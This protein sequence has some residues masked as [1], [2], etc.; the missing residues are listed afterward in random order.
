[1]KA[2]E[3]IDRALPGP[4]VTGAEVTG[5][6]SRFQL[7]ASR[8]PYYWRLLK[9]LPYGA[10]RRI[11]RHKCHGYRVMEPFFNGSYGL[12]MGGPSP[13]FSRNKLIPVY[14]CCRK[15]DNCNF[16]S[17]NI[18]N[19]PGRRAEP[20]VSFARDYVAEAGDL[21]SI[22]DGT[23]DFVLASHVLEHLANPLRGLQ[24]WR[25]VLRPGGAMLVIVPDRRGTFDH[26]R[27]PT[28][29]EHLEA[30]FRK[31]TTEQDLTH[32]D[33][34]LA[35]HDLALD[36]GAGSAAEFRQRCLNNATVRAM[37]HHVFVPEVL[38][39][40]FS[41]MQL[42]VLSVAIERPFHIVAFAQR[43]DAV[44]R[45]E[46]ERQNLVLQNLAFLQETAEWRNHDPLKKERMVRA[47][48]PPASLAK[49]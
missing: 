40:M 34:I 37:H 25:R 47:N 15:I 44:E 16:S 19:V 32:L 28:S 33:E 21:S 11:T 2:T 22:Q 48:R 45:E 4:D 38:V 1:M 42:R 26:R 5:S 27:T 43:V 17:Q 46:V 30:D 36:P 23:Y 10:T 13:I 9:S 6:I 29:F 12:E 7:L 31:N 24:E 39:Q 41:R 20:G 14:G 3:V 18:W 8:G 35:R 49:E